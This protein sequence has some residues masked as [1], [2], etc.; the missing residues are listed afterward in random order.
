[1]YIVQASEFPGS[2]KLG[3]VPYQVGGCFG[4]CLKKSMDR[5]SVIFYV[6]LK[7]VLKK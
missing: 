3:G 7:D 1:M 4:K 5:F 2:K 6:T